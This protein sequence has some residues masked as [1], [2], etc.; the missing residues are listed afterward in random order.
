MAGGGKGRE[1][2][3]MRLK[4]KGEK[5]CTLLVHSSVGESARYCADA[6]A[7]WLGDGRSVGVGGV[8]ERGG[9]SLNWGVD[10]ERKNALV[11]KN[12]R[13]SKRHLERWNH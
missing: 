2:G 10:G 4:A 11:D 1:G 7:L 13:A 8:T 6:V 9:G 12:T 5:T 3:V